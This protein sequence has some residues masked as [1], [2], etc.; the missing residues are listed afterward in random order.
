VSP[1]LFDEGDYINCLPTVDI[2]FSRIL[3][4]VVLQLNHG[5]QMSEIIGVKMA[6]EKSFIAIHI[7]TVE[8]RE[9]ERLASTA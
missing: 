2:D 4:N 5:Q 6:G 1:D 8:G 3:N 9:G 7:Y